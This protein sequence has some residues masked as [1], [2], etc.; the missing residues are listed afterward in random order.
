MSAAESFLFDYNQVNFEQFLELLPI[1]VIFCDQKFIIRY[2]N[3]KSIET[4][5]K[6]QNLL[7][8]PLEKI[9]GSSIDLFHK[10]PAHQRTML[11]KQ[12]QE[13]ITSIIRLGNEFLELHVQRYIVDNRYMGNIVSWT[14]ATEKLN[15]D[16]ILTSIDKSQAVIEFDSTGVILKANQNF[17]QTMGY[18]EGEILGKHHSIFC[19][20]SFRDSADYRQFWKELSEGISKS[21]TFL[22]VPKNGE[23]VYLQATYNAIM[24]KDGKVIKVIKF[25]SNVTTE[26]KNFLGILNV[27]GQTS[28]QLAT[29]SEELSATAN[30]LASNAG[31]TSKESS[32]ASSSSEKVSMGV[33]QMA[34]NMEE[35]SASIKEITRTTNEAS[36]MTNETSKKAK[37]ANTLITQLGKSSLDIGQVVKV[38]SSIAQQTNLLALN[39]TIEAA[40]AGDAGRGFAVVANEV[41]ELAKQTEKATG[42]IAKKVEAIQADTHN[43]VRAISDISQSGDLVNGNTSNI[44]AAV[45]EQAATTNEISR[46]VLES[47][48]SIDGVNHL[49]KNLSKVSETNTHDANELISAARELNKIA[50]NLKNLVTKLQ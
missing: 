33:R 40:R 15:M 23:E 6:I 31:Q 3:K 8:I 12:K 18:G 45:E 16:Y 42:D 5:Q 41:K 47:S 21:G 17:L 36:S 35:M 50:L 34:A 10:N 30:Q 38:I 48:Q 44:A 20:P 13:P 46:I 32:E 19:D 29:A 7:P 2:V 39:A 4:F 9:V 24:D 28:H 49:I 43:A 27:M 11:E 1:N 26:K 14:I 25:A 37:D 22:R